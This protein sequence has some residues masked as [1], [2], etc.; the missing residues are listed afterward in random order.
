MSVLLFVYLFFPLM[1][2]NIILASWTSKQRCYPVS[3]V[4]I[5]YFWLHLTY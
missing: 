5:T 4:V 1:V 2:R 3:L